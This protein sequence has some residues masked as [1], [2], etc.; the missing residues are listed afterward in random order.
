MWTIIG[1]LYLYTHSLD[2]FKYFN[3]IFQWVP[4]LTPAVMAELD[5]ILGNRP[6]GKREG[7]N[8]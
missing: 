3:E 8:R 5:K 1:N 6:G 2:I 4:K 7:F